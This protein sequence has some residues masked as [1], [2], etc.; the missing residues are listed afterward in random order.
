MK[1]EYYLDKYCAILNILSILLSNDWQCD[2]LDHTI[3]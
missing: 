2:A 3:A 1:T